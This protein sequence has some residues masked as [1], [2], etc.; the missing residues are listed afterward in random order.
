MDA[1]RKDGSEVLG[2]VAIFTYGFSTA[3]EKFKNAKVKLTAL[4]NYDAV[5]TEALATNYIL[6]ND[7]ETLREW[8]KNPSAWKKDQ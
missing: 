1:I 3:E 7:L 4:S 5:L 2:M 8:R 6:Q